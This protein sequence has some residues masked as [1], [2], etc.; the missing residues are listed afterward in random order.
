LDYQQEAIEAVAGIFD[1]GA[2]IVRGEGSTAI[3]RAPDAVVGNA[4]EVDEA[5]MLKNVQVIQ[6]ANKVEPKSTALGSMDFSVEMETGTGKTYV[7]LRTIL[8][9]R[10]RY[11]LTKFIILVPSVAIR[12]GVLKTLEQ[13]KEHFKDIFN[14]NYGYFVYDSGKLSQV[15]EFAQSLDVQIMIMTIQS[16]N[17]E[18]NIMRQTDRDDTYGEESYINLVAKTRPV[19][20]MDEPQNMES[21]LSKAAIGELNPLFRLRY[22]ATHRELHN[23]MYRLT[24]V[25]AY[26]RGLVKKIQVHGVREN[27]AGAFVFRVRKIEA[28]KG[29]SPRA[30]VVLEVKNA[31]GNYGVK[32]VTLKAGNDL[33]RKT[34]NDKYAGLTVND[35]NAQYNRVELSDG[36][37]HQLDVAMENREEVFRTQIRETIR[38]HLDKQESLDGRIK[39]LSLFF[40][41]KVD[42]YVHDDSLIRRLFIEEFESLKRNYP[43]FKDVPADAVHKGYFAS[44]KVRG[45]VE[46]Q[47]TRGESV[48]D[49]EAY[50]LIMKEKERLL[51]FSEPVSFIFSHSALKEGWD[52]PNIFQIC[53][54]RET[55]ST[56]KKRQEIGRGLRLPL[57]VD[58]ERV[59]ESA[60]NVLTVV[61]NESY[62]EYAAALQ[63]EFNE[64][65]YA[66]TPEAMD[67]KEKRITVKPVA[68]NL[69]TEEFK[70]LWR[71]ISVRTRFNIKIKTDE[72]VAKAVEEINK[73]DISNL[74]V[75][76]E[77]VAI[78]FDKDGEIKTIFSGQAVGA[79]LNKEIRIDNV[80]DRIA[81]ETGI[82]RGTTFKILSRVDNLEIVFENPEEYVR[83]VIIVVRGVLNDLLINDG[84]KYIP[85][86]DTW[87]VALLFTDF[88][89]LQRKSISGGSK[90]VYDAVVYDSNGER[91][92][93]ESLIDS[94]NV[95]LFTKLPRGFRVETPLGDYIPDWAIVWS[96][97][98]DRL[99]GEKLYLVRETK[100]GYADWEKELSVPE[101]Q[102]IVCGQKHFDAIGADFKVATKED[103]SD[104]LK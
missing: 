95:K 99:G 28:K 20:I 103:L 64:A 21:E 48:I 27:D 32:E 94:P 37:F 69:K 66:D 102:K 83:S 38:A 74:A 11:G 90:S 67:A 16:F 54:L 80:T 59:R 22:S 81:R 45:I 89:A 15:R 86:G 56:M 92:F 93:A 8:E 49:K 17:T 6:V 3:L 72:L 5:R 10:K 51:S 40:I 62:Q 87:E 2:N 100:F 26:R 84:L 19:V 85:T 36:S 73:R 42:N 24:P 23:L 13:T 31:A 58:G 18:T 35:V 63:Q 71:R 30:T 9:L 88:E 34:K 41:D 65:G 55:H 46:Y 91:E 104:L 70:E 44:K 68:K 97:N 14:T 61:A 4:L 52:N 98:P 77:R 96:P 53:T 60:V 29:M 43:R 1:T 76:V 50:D 12:E 82:T 75:T 33:L 78:D 57:T 7:Y 39:V 47:D 25:D 101:L 79:R